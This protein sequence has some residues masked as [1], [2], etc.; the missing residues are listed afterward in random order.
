MTCNRAAP[1]PFPRSPRSPR[2]GSAW[3]CS[4]ASSGTAPARP[5]GTGDETAQD[6]VPG[7]QLAA[8]LG[9]LAEEVQTLAEGSG[10]TVPAPAER[11]DEVALLG[12]LLEAVQEVGARVDGMVSVPV[13]SGAE[14][15]ALLAYRATVAAGNPYSASALQARFG[16]TRALG[17]FPADRV[18][19]YRTGELDAQAVDRAV[20]GATSTPRRAAGRRRALHAG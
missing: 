9:G 14:H 8:L 20:G 5:P 15:A 7:G 3:A 17:G 18:Q 19:R 10:G 11:T 13:P 1:Q 12:G 4:S 2:C 6:A 16:L